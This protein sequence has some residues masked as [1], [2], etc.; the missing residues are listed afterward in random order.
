MELMQ[1]QLLPERV[2]FIPFIGNSLRLRQGTPHL[3]FPERQLTF[4]VILLDPRLRGIGSS[5]GAEIKLSHIGMYRASL[6][7]HIPEK[8]SR[9]GH[10]HLRAAFQILLAFRILDEIAGRAAA[11]VPVAIRKQEC[12]QILFLCP[13]VPDIV[14]FFRICPV[15]KGSPSL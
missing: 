6:F 9:T 4:P 15:G 12:V 5:V 3:H 8:F 7:F 1:Q 14:Y 2:R 10:L 13:V 11:S